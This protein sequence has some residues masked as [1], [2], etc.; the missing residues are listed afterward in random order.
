[1]ERDRFEQ[2]FLPERERL[3]AYLAGMTGDRDAALDAAQEAFLAAWRDIETFRE[4]SAPLTWLI[5]IARRIV[6]RESRR[7][8]RREGLWGSELARYG[9]MGGAAA[10]DDAA[11]ASAASDAEPGRAIE[12][13][14]RE[15]RVRAAILLLPRERREAVVLHYFAGMSVAEIAIALRTREGTIK[16][17]L[18]RARAELSKRLESDL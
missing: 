14:E 16:S 13:C 15:E 11:A 8:R 7:E 1:M 3:L 17:R 6:F 4:E 5:G 10:R 18:A 12:E 2:L 9:G